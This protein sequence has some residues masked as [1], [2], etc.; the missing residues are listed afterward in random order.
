MAEDYPT[1]LLDFERRFAN[2]AA[3]REYLAGLRWPDGF[4]CREC[5][6]ASAWQ[7]DRGRWRCHACRLDTSVMAGTVFQDSKLSLMLWFRAMWFITSQKYGA[8][9]LGVQR[10]LGLRSYKT[11]WALLHKLRHAMVRQGRE[12]LTGAVEVDEAYW[13]GEEEGVIGRKLVKKALI[14]IAVEERGKASGRIRLRQIYGADRSSLHG[15]IRENIEPG[16]TIHT[17]G[18]LAYRG[19]LNYEHDPRVQGNPKKTK[20]L[21][22]AHRVISLLKRWLLGTHQGAIEA[23]YLDYYLDEFTFRF[24]R[25]TSQSRG[26][27][28]FRLVQQAAQAAPLPVDKLTDHH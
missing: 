11:A 18:L 25:R 2:E 21:P 28:F 4:V 17:D 16:S 22:H 3:C 19:L 23:E 7:T 27:L 20:L 9:A 10:M 13:G 8:S 1:T 26:K 12:R 15:F 5:G 24:N 14:A 6:G